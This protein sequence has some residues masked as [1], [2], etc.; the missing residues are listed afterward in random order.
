MM[1][2][3]L[4]LGSM[5]GPE[6]LWTAIVFLSIGIAL[7]PPCYLTLMTMVDPDSLGLGR[8]AGIV[9]A[10][11]TIG[12][13][14]GGALAA[15]SLKIQSISLE[16]LLIALVGVMIFSVAVLYRHRSGVPVE[17]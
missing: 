2:G 4:L 9:S 8:K 16:S 3:S 15:F 11:N 6:Q 12:Y 14:L 7:I 1:V 5:R 10:A 13:T 17:A